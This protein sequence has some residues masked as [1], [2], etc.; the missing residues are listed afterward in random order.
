VEYYDTKDGKWHAAASRTVKA[1]GY[2]VAA[3]GKYLYAFGGFAYSDAHSPKWKSLDVIERY[4]TEADTWTVVGSLPRPRSSNI[5][6]IVNDKAYLI[7]GWDSTPKSPGDM[8]GIFHR[9]I[10]M[11]D[12]RTEQASETGF[13]IPDPLRRA[14][15]SVTRGD[16]IILV[17]GIGEGA[18]HF[19]LLDYVTSFN[20]KT[21]TW[22]E[23]PRLPFATFA[24]AAGLMG[25]KLF[26]FGGMLN[27]TKDDLRFG[28][29][30][31]DYRYINHV[32]EHKLGT[33]HWQHSGRYLKDSKGFS[34][35][36][37]L[38]DKSLGVLGG[39]SYDNGQD[40]PV[41]T[42]ENFKSGA[43]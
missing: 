4:D 33:D 26:M 3:Y 37:E 43:S 38:E 5:I 8:D 7:G 25:D 29:E 30:D 14:F 15:S 36:V 12:L 11:F 13:T 28:G 19:E 16:E 17:G 18:S 39:H 22:K 42:F 10:D 6:G 31:G 21:N 23:L 9:E 34:M 24:P 40:A 41:P 27:I 35:V 1:H 2:T 20:P 32:F